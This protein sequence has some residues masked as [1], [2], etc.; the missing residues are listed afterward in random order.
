MGLLLVGGLS[1]VWS[2]QQARKMAQNEWDAVVKNSSI[3]MKFDDRGNQRAL[4]FWS[5]ARWQKNQEA[6]FIYDENSK[7]GEFLGGLA[8]A[9][10][11]EDWI[12][13]GEQ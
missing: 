6:L 3:P 1:Q 4:V 9:A 13:S 2:I 8:E 12:A 11:E 10:E 7:R 5:R